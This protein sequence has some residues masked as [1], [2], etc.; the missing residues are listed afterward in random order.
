MRGILTG[1]FSRRSM[2]NQG[3]INTMDPDGIMVNGQHIGMSIVE[4]LALL[5]SQMQNRDVLPQFPKQRVPGFEL[6]LNPSWYQL[7]MSR[8]DDMMLSDDNMHPA[9]SGWI[10]QGCI[11]IDLSS[12]CIGG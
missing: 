1:T 2:E 7:V 6:S 9:A 4:T 5:Q 12:R 11:W 10:Y 3:T 8:E